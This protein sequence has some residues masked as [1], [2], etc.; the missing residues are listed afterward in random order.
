MITAS[1]CYLRRKKFNDTEL[2]KLRLAGGNGIINFQG[3]TNQK[4]HG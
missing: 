1:V 2:W 4:R 3:R